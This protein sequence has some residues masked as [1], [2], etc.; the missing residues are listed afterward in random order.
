[1]NETLPISQAQC[2]KATNWLIT[3]FGDKIKSAVNGT[4]FTVNHVC[5]IACQETAQRW[6]LWIDEYNVDTVLARCVFDASGDMKG[7]TR[8]AFPKNKAEFQAKY[9]EEFTK[10][11]IDEANKMRAM[12]QPGYKHGYHPADYL[13]KGY[14]IFQYDL[15]NVVTDRAF[16]EHKLWYQFDNC[17]SRLMIELRRKYNAKQEV[18]ASIKAYNGA[19]QAAENYKNNVKQF[20]EWIA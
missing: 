17:L 12:P 13:Y 20:T 1:M 19:G 4:P 14:S 15:Q 16:F 7:T 5:A 8:N 9:G 11:L 6:L 3:N 18:W 2:I 10:M